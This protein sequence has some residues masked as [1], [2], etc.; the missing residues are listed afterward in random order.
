M[1]FLS[2]YKKSGGAELHSRNLRPMRVLRV[3]GPL[4]GSDLEAL[5]K[6]PHIS[7]VALGNGALAGLPHAA[8]EQSVRSARCRQ[9]LLC[10]LRKLDADEV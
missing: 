2:L 1:G 4:D 7:S 10:L 3:C 9:G 6:A 5:H 8:V